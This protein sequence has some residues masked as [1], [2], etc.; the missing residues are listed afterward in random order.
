MFK[1]I[2]ANPQLRV[3]AD[4]IISNPHFADGRPLP[5]LIVNATTAPFIAEYIETHH[6]HAPGDVGLYWGSQRFSNELVALQVT[7]SRPSKNT[8]SILFD[9]KTQH[10]LVDAILHGRGFY[11]QAGDDGTKLSNSLNAPKIV[12]EVPDLGFMPKWEKIVQCVLAGRF[13]KNGFSKAEANTA[14]SQY[15]ASMREFWAI[16]RKG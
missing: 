14:V 5:I 11:L 8:F 1:K 4:G 12:I 10:V 6:L 16:R 9:T 2:V 7:L 3:I 15:L 13:R